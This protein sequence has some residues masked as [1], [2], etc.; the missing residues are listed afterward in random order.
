MQLY[1][2]GQLN[3]AIYHMSSSLRQEGEALAAMARR[4]NWRHIDI[5]IDDS[6]L[7]D[8][9]IDSFLS[10]FSDYGTISVIHLDRV[11]NMR[12]SVIKL[13]Q[14][15]S[16][17][18]VSIQSYPSHHWL[19]PDTHYSYWISEQPHSVTADTVVLLHVGSKTLGDL[20]DWAEILLY[21]LDIQWIITSVGNPERSVHSISYIILHLLK[22]WCKMSCSTEQKM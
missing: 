12:S 16:S 15:I 5:V 21:D 11:K 3:D 22:S 4:S 8:G 17:A 13:H 6:L 9:L 1:F 10:E 2:Q 18:V 20:M 14:T 19:R 7:Y